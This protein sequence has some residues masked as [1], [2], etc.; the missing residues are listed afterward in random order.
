MRKKLL[1]VPAILQILVLTFFMLTDLKA[2]EPTTSVASLQSATISGV[3]R[4]ATDNL[5]LPGVNVLEKGT[6]NGAVTDK[7]GRYTITIINTDAVLEFSYVGFLTVQEKVGGRTKIDVSLTEKT[8]EISEVVVVGYGVQKKSDLTGAV[9][10][11]RADEMQKLTVPSIAEAL[12]G[13]ASG[14][15]VSKSS[16]A[17]GAGASIFIRGPGSVNGT[18]PLWIIDGIPGGGGNNLDLQDV[19]SVEIL[20]DASSAAIYGAKGANGVILVTTKRGKT[21]KPKINFSTSYALTQPMNLY[22]LVN[23]QDFSALRYESYNNAGFAAGLAQIYTR[24]VNNPDTLRSLP[25]SNDWMDVLYKKG[26]IKDY[27]FDF[28]G[29][30]ENSNFYTSVGYFKEEG[31]Y[32]G[33]SFERISIRLNSDHRINKWI[34]VGQSI[35]LSQTASDGNSYGFGASMRVNPFMQLLDSTENNAYTPYDALPGEYGFVGPNPWGVEMI[36]QQLGKGQ[37]VNGSAYL[38]IKPIKG[39]SWKTTFGGGIGW[40]H[41]RSYTERYDLGYTLKRDVD[42]L[43]IGVSTGLGYTGNTVLTYNT[44]IGKHSFD[45]MIGAEIQDSKGESYSMYGENFTDGLII[46]DKSDVLQRTLSGSKNAPVRWSSQFAR[47]NYS[48]D[49]KYLFTFNMRRDGSSV[50]PPGKRF[51]VFP[52][53]SAGWRITKEKF[54]K[55]LAAIMDLKLRAGWGSVG[56]ATVG[57]FQYYPQ[58]GGSNIYYLFGNQ[59]QT[60]VLPT[61]F[62]AGDLQWESINT[63]NIGFDMNLFDFRLNITNDFYLKD[64]RDMLIYVDLPPSAGMGLNASTLTNAGNIRNI[65][66]DLSV[67]WRETRGDF[68]YNIGGNFS[69]NRHKVLDLIDKS[70]NTGNL[71]Q[72]KTIAGEPMSYYEG[73]VVERLWQQGEEQDIIEYL[74]KNN[75]LPNAES[76]STSKYTGPGDFKYMDMNKDSLINDLDRVKIGNPWPKFVYGFN[77]GC[78]YKGFDFYLFFQGVSGNDIYHFNKSMTHNLAGD[79]S[80]TYAAFNRWTPENPDEDEPRIIYTD[81][82]GNMST[83][84]SYFV[85]KGSYLRLKNLQVGYTLPKAFTRK[86]AIESLRIYLSGQNLLTF[87]KYSGL[88]PELSNG[89][90]TS[91]NL[92]QG[93]YP[94]NQM[95]QIGAQLSF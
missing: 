18:E 74:I 41:N 23:A 49:S 57:P 12:Q 26:A 90:N 33:T 71:R 70:I 38:N 77:L 27:K 31:T 44:E 47:L 87:T 6:Q 76:Y 28:S 8:K 32:I 73:Y 9:E 54:M 22:E 20:K 2:K 89:S 52:S 45:G 78:D 66:N 7:D 17:P 48:F 42:V 25:P 50:F 30:N 69:W 59:L 58:F 3:V 4:S 15:F 62:G 43:N 82:N 60:G 13:K 37:N 1:S 10:S 65:G 88:D 92:D 39:L 53:F 61:V 83:S 93:M 14:V 63:S 40:G 56:N 35:H 55:G 34:E 46:F 94:Q 21:G 72:F 95:F 91:R 86:V 16:G 75:K 19:E 68:Q 85:E 81:P 84:S 67:Q 80:F 24:I 29:G 64:T 5:P 11:V 79:Y 36:N 51:G